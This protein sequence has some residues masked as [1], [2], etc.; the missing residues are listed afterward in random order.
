M[1]DLS[2]II[3][4]Y[5][6]RELLMKCL[7]SL[8]HCNTAIVQ[9]KT[10]IIVVDNGS[11]DGTVGEL[12]NLKT[13]KQKNNLI[14]IENKEN[15]GFSKA[16]NIGIR[17]ASGKYILL[18]N[19]DTVV[20]PETLASMIQFMEINLKSG[21]ATC[22]V[23]LGDGN[24]DPACHRGFPTPWASLTYF[25]SL[26]KLFPS[27]KFFGQYHLGYL[28]MDHPHEIDSPSGAFYLVR[29]EVIDQVGLLDED[30]FIYGEDLDWS[31]RIKRAGWKIMYNPLVK[32]THFKKQSGRENE[33]PKLR[34]E[35]Q[36]HFYE[37]M[38]LFYKKHYQDKYPKIVTFLI[39]LAIEV[40]QKLN[41]LQHSR[42]L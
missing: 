42:V 25:L 39:L 27:S 17:Q 6:T 24:L 12:K 8:Y 1:I 10:E 14:I 7:V 3:V 9:N 33:D 30:Y 16:N 36:K 37:T 21:S 2:I 26:E 15:L 18:L 38:K 23:E 4:T 22:R 32:I 31:Y 20:F 19:S 11:M 40:K 28:P 29:R 34:Q 5:N 13:E 41:S 35:T